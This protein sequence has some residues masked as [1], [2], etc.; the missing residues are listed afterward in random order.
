MRTPIFQEGRK[1]RITPL[2]ALEILA[3]C[4][5]G[6]LQ[7]SK[8]S[9][10]VRGNETFLMDTTKFKDWQD[11]K[12]DMNGTYPHVLTTCT[13]TVKIQKDTFLKVETCKVICQEIQQNDRC[14]LKFNFKKI[15]RGCVD[16]FFLLLGKSG[17]VINN[18]CRYHITTGEDTVEFEVQ[19]HGSSVQFIFP[20]LAKNAY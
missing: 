2:E 9:L 20:A 18:T 11:I 1:E 19:S 5:N 17:D 14:H 12:N 10:R 16:Q 8:V 6:K 15:T 13:W 3:K 4:N 7:C